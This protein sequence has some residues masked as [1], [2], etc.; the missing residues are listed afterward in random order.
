[1]GSYIFDVSERNNNFGSSVITFFSHLLELL[2]KHYDL[3]VH[4]KMEKITK[5]EIIGKLKP[6]IV[7][8]G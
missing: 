4:N 6:L 1:M 8:L 2:F 7:E 3:P 5:R